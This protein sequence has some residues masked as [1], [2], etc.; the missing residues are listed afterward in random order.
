MQQNRNEND[1]RIAKL[2]HLPTI[3]ATKRERERSARERDGDDFGHTKASV[4]RTIALREDDRRSRR[5]MFWV[6]ISLRAKFRQKENFKFSKLENQV[7]WRF[8]IA[9]SEKLNS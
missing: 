2:L 5:A 6:A 1:K 4:P 9:K 8:S 3:A 7:I